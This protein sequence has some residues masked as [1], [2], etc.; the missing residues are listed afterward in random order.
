MQ[1]TV[2]KFLPEAVEVRRVGQKPAS[3]HVGFILSKEQVRCLSHELR[4]EPRW[5]V[6]APEAAGFRQLF[7]CQQLQRIGHKLAGAVDAQSRPLQRLKRVLNVPLYPCEGQQLRLAGQSQGNVVGKGYGL[8]RVAEGF[9][10]TLIAADISDAE[11]PIR[12][13]G[14]RLA[15]SVNGNVSVSLFGDIKWFSFFSH[16]HSKNRVFFVRRLCCC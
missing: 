14:L 7:G 8:L 2:S 11:I 9:A 5:P 16:T 15:T 4:R 6:V 3:L 13:V 10:L 1:E 12:A